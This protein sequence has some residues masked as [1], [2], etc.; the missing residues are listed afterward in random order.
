MLEGNFNYFGMGYTRERYAS[1]YLG[2]NYSWKDKYIFNT[3]V[4]EDGSNRLGESQ[5][6][7]WLPTWNVSG[8]WNIDTE[9]F[10]ENVRFIDFLTLK[11]GYGLTANVGNAT[12]SS[13]VYRSSNT[14]RPPPR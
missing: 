5:T 2:A 10:M 11:A 13:V 12:N 14:Q 8:A 9:G 1:F 6:A 7:R 4:R 3:T